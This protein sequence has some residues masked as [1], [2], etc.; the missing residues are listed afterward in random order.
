M[1]R[2]TIALQYL[3]GKAHIQQDG[4]GTMEIRCQMKP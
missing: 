3:K 4:P 1:G 2:G